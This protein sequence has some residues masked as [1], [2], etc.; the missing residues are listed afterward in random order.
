[1]S[2]SKVAAIKRFFESMPNGRAV[3]RQE[4]LEMS[5]DAEGY[6]WL[7]N[8]SARALGETLENVNPA[9]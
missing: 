9:Q 5:K 7:A 8:E 1:M 6:L 4:L 2:I 3:T